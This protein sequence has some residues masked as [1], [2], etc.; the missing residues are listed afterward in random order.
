MTKSEERMLR[1][2]EE[3]RKLEQQVAELQ[4]EISEIT[5]IY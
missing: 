3:L 4:D 1:K 2:I 5:H